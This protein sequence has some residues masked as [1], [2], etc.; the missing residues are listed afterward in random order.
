MPRL[1]RAGPAQAQPVRDDRPD[2][3]RR[4]RA[5][6]APSA[7]APA[8]ARPQARR[9]RRA[10]RRPRV[11][12]VLLRGRPRLRVAAR[13][14]GCRSP[15]WRPPRR[16]SARAADTHAELAVRRCAAASR[17]SIAT[18]RRL[19]RRAVAVGR[20]RR[21]HH[22]AAARRPARPPP[23]GR[24]SSPTKEAAH[25]VGG[26]DR[27]RPRVRRSSC[28]ALARRPGGGRVLAGYLIEKSLSASTTSSCGR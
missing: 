14:S 11:D 21:A 12:R 10:R 1:P 24:T 7:A 26:V 15:G 6:S 23:R 27:D 17:P 5:A 19:R 9:L 8:E 3:R 16:C 13:R 20:V 28:C 22:R 25:R 2:R 18:L 4:A